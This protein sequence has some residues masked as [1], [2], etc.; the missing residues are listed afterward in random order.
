[1][2]YIYHMA[3]TKYVEEGGGGNVGSGLEA[4]DERV[5]TSLLP[6]GSKFDVS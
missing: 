3:T 2:L 5:M 6:F 1:M 4:K